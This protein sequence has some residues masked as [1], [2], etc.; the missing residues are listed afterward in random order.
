MVNETQNEIQ[1]EWQ[2]SQGCG[3]PSPNHHQSMRDM[4]DSDELCGLE[5]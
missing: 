5:L 3:S 2:P 4:R 1:L